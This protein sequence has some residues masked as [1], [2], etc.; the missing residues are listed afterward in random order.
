MHAYFRQTNL[1]KMFDYL[2][3]LKIKGGGDV[4][5]NSGDDPWTMTDDQLLG[6]MLGWLD[7]WVRGLKSTLSKPR[8]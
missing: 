7:G 5:N 6:L 2:I 3:K 4:A 8:P 1:D